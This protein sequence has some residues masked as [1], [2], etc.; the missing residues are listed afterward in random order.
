M[1]EVIMWSVITQN[2]EHICIMSDHVHATSDKNGW[3]KETPTFFS[4]PLPAVLL[5]LI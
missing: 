2:L 5:E 4:S 3:Q 1:G